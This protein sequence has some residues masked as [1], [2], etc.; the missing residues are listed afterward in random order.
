MVCKGNMYLTYRSCGPIKLQ[1]LG[2]HLDTLMEIL[3]LVLNIPEFYKQQRRV[4]NTYTPLKPKSW[5]YYLKKTIVL[6]NK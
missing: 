3:I 1:C 2:N 6:F 4:V 5:R